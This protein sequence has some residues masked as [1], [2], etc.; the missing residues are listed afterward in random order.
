MI[1]TMEKKYYHGELNEE[2]EKNGIINMIIINEDNE[3]I[4]YQGI[5]ENDKLNDI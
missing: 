3:K 5:W 2:G 4:F 1:M